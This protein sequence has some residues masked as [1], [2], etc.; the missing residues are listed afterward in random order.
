MIKRRGVSARILLTIVIGCFSTVPAYAQTLI[1]PH[2]Q[3]SESTLGQNGSP[4]SS[5]T[6]YQGSSSVGDLG[7][8]TSLGTKYGFQGGSQT[9]GAPRLAVAV[10]S[11]AVT[12]PI[13]DATTPAMGTATFQ[14][15]NYTSYGYSVFVTGNPPTNSSG[16]HQIQPMTTLGTSSPGFEQFGMNVVANTAPQ[17]IGAN[18]DNGTYNFGYGA[19]G[20]VNNPLNLNYKTPNKYTYN[21]GDLIASA[22]KSGGYTNYTITYLINVSH[23]TPGGTYN[24]NQS[25]VVVGTY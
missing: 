3:L 19:A 23:L 1:S 4:N 18:P 7:V 14:V 16:G 24:S 10:I 9:T 17:T 13:F 8:G 25:L 21:N 15:L 22:N 12:F 2:Y 6:N 20:D 11:N 5:S